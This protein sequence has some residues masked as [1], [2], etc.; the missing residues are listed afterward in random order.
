MVAPD[1]SHPPQEWSK[2][3]KRIYLGWY[4]QLFFDHPLLQKERMSLWS[5]CLREGSTPEIRD[6]LALHGG[7]FCSTD[8]Q[9]LDEVEKFLR[10]LD[11]P[12][13]D[14][15]LTCW[16]DTTHPLY[17]HLNIRQSIRFM[18]VGTSLA[19]RSHLEDMRRE[20]EA[21]PQ[22]YVV[23]DLERLS[24]YYP[25]PSFESPPNELPPDVPD[26]VRGVFPWSEP[27]IFR[28]GRYSVHRV[29]NPLKAIITPGEL[30]YSPGS[31]PTVQD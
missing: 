3:A 12:P 20:V 27:V 13:G 11:H 29:Q 31:L 6:R 19:F 23:S 8:W 30:K 21:T 5:K 7:I 10:R 15:E 1:F 9:R 25:I 2:M 4:Y 24:V 18:H 14:R 17:L 28:A 16:D 22:R 26:E